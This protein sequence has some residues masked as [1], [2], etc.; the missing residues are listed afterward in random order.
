MLCDLHNHS[1][2]SDGT[3]SPA[4]LATEAARAGL[5]AAALTD[6]NTTAGLC[7][8]VRAA[9]ELGVEPVPGVEIST[10][11]PI[12]GKAKEFHVLALF[13]DEN[14]AEK[15]EPMLAEVRRRSDSSKRGL[16]DRLRAGGYNVPTYDE[17]RA[18][19]GG[20]SINRAHV[21]AHMVK[22]GYAADRREVFD[23]ILNERAGFYR[24]AERFDS[25]EVIRTIKDIGAVSVLAHPLL[26]LDAQRLDG[27]ISEAAKAG[28]DGMEVHCSEYDGQQT[29]QAMQL[30]DRYALAYSGGSDFHGGNKPH[31]SIGSGR[32]NLAVPY[33]WYE[34]LKAISEKRS[35]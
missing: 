27:F 14:S 6:H 4:Q 15:L 1:R 12:D 32:G 5:G 23:G 35:G 26:K 3:L 20:V 7:E 34:K 19:A 28:L 31:I 24:P 25:L 22:L 9:R 33:E 11:Y 8:F 16:V 30:A 13:L 21:A 10:E 18:Q 29:A 17:I 2:C